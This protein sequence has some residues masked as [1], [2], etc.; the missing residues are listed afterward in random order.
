MHM[1]QTL[2]LLTQAAHT[3][4]Q[5]GFVQT[6]HQLQALHDQITFFSDNIAYKEELFPRFF[7]IAKKV[8]TS[9]QTQLNNDSQ[10][11]EALT[12]QCQQ[13]VQALF[14][15][16]TYMMEL[17][18]QEAKLAGMDLHSVKNKKYFDSKKNEA[19]RLFNEQLNQLRAKAELSHAELLAFNEYLR[20]M[21]EKDFGVN[22]LPKAQQ[23]QTQAD[24]KAKMF[25]GFSDLM[26]AS[27]SDDKEKLT[28]AGRTFFGSIIGMI[29]ETIANICARFAPS[30]APLISGLAKF[31]KGSFSQW[32]DV[33]MEEG[34]Y[35]QAPAQ[36]PSI[37]VPRP[38]RPTPTPTP[39]K[40][41][42]PIFN[43]VSGAQGFINNNLNRV[44]SFLNSFR[45]TPT[46][47]TPN[48]VKPST[49]MPT[50]KF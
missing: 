42:S 12:Q 31:A 37:S 44:N 6:Q 29:V 35:T 21:L 4:G 22:N 7:E 19:I 41:V 43:D 36:Q 1:Q 30:L 40:P 9:I 5:K 24:N 27:N 2:D 34:G 13:V 15:T 3:A 47:A 8:V 18:T 26:E 49:W 17:E 46:Q 39:V 10:T 33:S 11:D 14:N 16:R 32:F 20:K 48:P 38:S 28:N 23:P 45:R 25:K 50:L